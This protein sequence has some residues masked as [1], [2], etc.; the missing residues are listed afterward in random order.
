MVRALTAARAWRSACASE[1]A[2]TNTATSGVSTPA[3]MN[4]PLHA[5]FLVQAA[6]TTGAAFGDGF[7]M[8]RGERGPERRDEVHGM[9][10]G[11]ERVPALVA[12]EDQRQ[13]L[14]RVRDVVRGGAR[15]AVRDALARAPARL[16]HT[17]RR[18]TRIPNRASRPRRRRTR[19][20]LAPCPRCARKSPSSTA[21]SCALAAAAAGCSPRPSGP[22]YVLSICERSTPCSSNSF[23]AS[24]TASSGSISKSSMLPW[25]H[26][27]KASCVMRLVIFTA[28]SVRCGRRGA[29]KCEIQERRTTEVPISKVLTVDSG[30]MAET[31]RLSALSL[32]PPKSWTN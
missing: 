14:H 7:R 19:G 18:R 27:S 4:A 5:S 16:H 29:T 23:T 2:S 8:R 6:A 13:R 10:E 30:K 28:M 31:N 22:A 11:N 15:R 9:A 3:L 12:R 32:A 20:A 17:P 21:A 26:S 1:A 25:T 24:S